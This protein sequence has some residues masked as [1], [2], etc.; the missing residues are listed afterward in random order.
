M[1]AGLHPTRLSLAPSPHQT[2][3]HAQRRHPG[4]CRHSHSN[5][6]S[7]LTHLRL[8]Q[9]VMQNMTRDQKHVMKAS[10]MS[11]VFDGVANSIHSSVQSAGDDTD[12]EDLVLMEGKKKKMKK[13]QSNQ[14]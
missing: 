11:P 5:I 2:S 9:Q 14:I 12:S 6:S 3:S 4:L 8:C 1:L 7:A 13:N 10:E